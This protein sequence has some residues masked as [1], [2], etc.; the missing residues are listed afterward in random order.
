MVVVGLLVGLVGY[1]YLVFYKVKA[2]VKLQEIKTEGEK[3]KGQVQI[4]VEAVK[5]GMAKLGSTP[6]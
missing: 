1:F 4:Q 6:K 5:V 2:V 3:A